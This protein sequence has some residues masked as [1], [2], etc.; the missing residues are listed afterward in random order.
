MTEVNME[1]KSPDRMTLVAFFLTV[2]FAGN[3]A[4]AV[5][6][7]NAD[8]P[9]FFGAASRF[10]V[11]AVILLIMVLVLR[12]PLPRGRGLQGAVI[13]GILST[14]INFA[15]MYWALQYIQPGLSMVI[16]ALTPL[17]TFLFAWA[18]RQ[19]AFQWWSRCNPALL[20]SLPGNN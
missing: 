18:H 7:S 8:L 14:G 17:L 12:L 4:I 6:F 9:P 19:E 20:A 16:L 3:N 13:Y 1:T 11:A 5:K 15:L 10:A 2:L